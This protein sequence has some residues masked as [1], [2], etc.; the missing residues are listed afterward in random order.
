MARYLGPRIPAWVEATVEGW[1]GLT[2]NREK[3]RIV[4]LT[5][6]QR[7][8]LDF[9]GYSFRFDWDRYGRGT[10]YFTAVPSTNA[11]T[12]TKGELRELINGRRNYEPVPVLIARVNRKLR[13]WQ[14]YFSFGRPRGAY[15]AMNAFVIA[16]LTH[17][18]QRRS[19][20]AF[21]PP[22]D[23]SWYSFLTGPLGVRLL[24]M[25]AAPR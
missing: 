12:R 13:G 9:L 16:R 7:E 2:I 15:R 25:R 3:T 5:P 10:R 24:T 8:S 21:R 4:R 17:H 1:L 6:K 18:L 19:Q 11:L 14:N 23:M 20:R 22:E